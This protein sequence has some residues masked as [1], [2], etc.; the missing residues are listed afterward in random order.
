MSSPLTLENSL[1]LAYVRT[2]PDVQRIRGLV[3]HCPERPVIVRKAERWRV[4]PSV[5]LQLANPF[6]GDACASKSAGLV[7][8][9]HFEHVDLTAPE[10]REAEQCV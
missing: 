5:Y 8:F 6:R 3:E 4:V 7:H 10:L 9:G 1:I 2:E